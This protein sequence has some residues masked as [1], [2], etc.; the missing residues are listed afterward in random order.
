MAYQFIFIDGNY[1]T[2]SRFRPDGQ[3]LPHATLVNWIKNKLGKKIDSIETIDIIDVS[4]QQYESNHF[5][6][7]KTFKLTKD[8]ENYT[9]SPVLRMTMEKYE[10][11]LRRNLKR[12]KEYRRLLKT[13]DPNADINV[14]AEQMAKI[15]EYEKGIK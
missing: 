6:L 11:Q 14:K 1:F 13:Y 10:Q 15:F 8:G 12:E 7:A 5:F 2:R 9:V 4:Q 3:E